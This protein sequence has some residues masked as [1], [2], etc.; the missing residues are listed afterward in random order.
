MCIA[1]PVKIVAVLDAKNATVLVEG[2]HGQEEVSAALVADPAQLGTDLLDRWAVV[3]SGF[4]L[5][6]LDEQEA[7]SRLAIFAAMD[8]QPVASADLR[9]DPEEDARRQ[10]FA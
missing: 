1:F 3:H 2:T 6:L 5:S 7:H 9:P 10:P 4:V 8:G